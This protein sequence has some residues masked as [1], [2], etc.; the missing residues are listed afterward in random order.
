MWLSPVPATVPVA[1]L[2]DDWLVRVA[3]DTARKAIRDGQ[4]WATA[5]WTAI[6]SM[7]RMGGG[8]RGRA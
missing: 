7:L 1:Y 5:Q 4:A 2:G 6:A 3:G 8:R